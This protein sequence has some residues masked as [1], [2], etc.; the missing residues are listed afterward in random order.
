M[1][2][3]PRAA[4][5]PA[6]PCAILQ[7]D[8][9]RLLSATGRAV[10]TGALA[11]AGIPSP[12]GPAG[13]AIV[14]GFDRLDGIRNVGNDDRYRQKSENWAIFTHNIVHL[15]DRLDVT[16]G[17]RYT[18]ENKDLRATFANNNT[19]CLTQKVI[20][21]RSWPMPGLRILLARAA[22]A[23]L[24]GQFHHGTSMATISQSA[25][26]ANG[27]APPSVS[28][29]PVDSTLFYASY[30]RGYKAG[31]FNLDRSAPPAPQT[32]FPCPIQYRVYSPATAVR[33][34]TRSATLLKS[35]R[36]IPATLPA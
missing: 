3:T 13:P 19:A 34:G 15:T 6:A 2:A 24:P 10:L 12:F 31:G 9:H 21:H 23:E 30:S 35:A 36:N 11:G 8:R 18:H 22:G 20:W 7:P 4:S 25:A 29:K 1:A 26:K 16:V 14:A 27:R 5:L 28:W 33:A 17:V 32:I